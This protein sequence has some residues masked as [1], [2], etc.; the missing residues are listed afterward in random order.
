MNI[1][2]CT[3]HANDSTN[4]KLGDSDGKAQFCGGKW[5]ET[6]A[7]YFMPSV[8]RK[9][10]RCEYKKLHSASQVTN[11]QYKMKKVWTL[12]TSLHKASQ[13]ICN[14]IQ[15]LILFPWNIAG[16]VY[17]MSDRRKS[18][19]RVVYVSEFSLIGQFKSTTLFVV[20]KRW[21]M[22]QI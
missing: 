15:L 21:I 14:S 1:D 19:A 10:K 3:D 8:R 11:W 13:Q 2:K 18:E 16:H 17:N 9:W 5:C 4:V 12:E 22:S 20:V 6:L 7:T